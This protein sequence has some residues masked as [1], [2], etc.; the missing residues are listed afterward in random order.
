MAMGWVV[1]NWLLADVVPRPIGNENMTAAPSGTFE[2]EMVL[3]NIAANKQDQFET[4]CALLDRLDLKDDPR[5]KDRE[6]RKTNRYVLK[7]ELEKALAAKS[8]A[9]WAELFNKKGV[10][11]GEVLD[12]PTILEHEQLKSRGFVKEFGEAP[13]VDRPVQVIRTG[14]RL[15]SGDPGPQTP[16]PALGAD[17]HEILKS[18][19][20]SD[21]GIQQLEEAGVV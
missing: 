13:A 4:L 16:P 20:Y 3:L 7:Q 6:D 19:G 17:T 12:V 18:L 8:A 21:E 11:A 10:P 5:F 14:F 15:A 1:S 2:P 9:Q